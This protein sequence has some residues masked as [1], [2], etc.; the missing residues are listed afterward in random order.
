MNAR[1][2]PQVGDYVINQDYKEG[3]AAIRLTTTRMR[4]PWDLTMRI[5]P[6]NCENLWTGLGEWRGDVPPQVG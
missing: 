4:D 3:T 6:L 5:W 1:I 2:Q